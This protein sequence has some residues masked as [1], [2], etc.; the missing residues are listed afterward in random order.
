MKKRLLIM[1]FGIFV[2]VAQALAQQTTVTG[3]VFDEDRLPL[4]GASVRVKG[5]ATAV[6]TSSDGYYSIKASVG[7]TLVFSFVG[8]ITQEITIKTQVIDVVLKSDAN[9]LSEVKITGAMGIKEEKRALGASSQS[10]KGSEVAQT[11]REN[12]INGLQ[13]RVAG[14]TI[15]STSGAPGAS[16]SIILRG[17]SSIN[18]SNQ[19]LIVIDGIPSDNNTFATGELASSGVTATSFENRGVDFTNRSSDFSPEDIEDITVLKGPEA[20]AL[21]GIDAANGAIIITTKRGKAGEGRINYS[22]AFKINH[23]T[24][25]PEVQRVYGPGSSGLDDETYAY[26]GSKY[27]EGT[28][29]Y[30]NISNFFQTSLTQKH[31]LSFEGGAD[32]ATYRIS[33][34]YNNQKDVVP[35]AGYDRFTLNGASTAK[36]NN[37]F[38]VDLSLTYSYSKNDKVFKGAGGPLIGLLMWPATDDASNYLTPGGL[39]RKIFTGISYANEIDNPYFSINKN[40]LY[41]INNRVFAATSLVITPIKDLSFT[42]RVGFDVG[43][44]ESMTFQ[45]P[46]SAAAYTRKGA[47]NQVTRTSQNLNI[48]SFVRYS[49]KIIPKL[50][51]NVLGGAEIKTEESNALSTYGEKFLEPNFESINNTDGLSRKVLTTKYQRRVASIYGQVQFNYDKILYVTAT[52]RNDWTSTLPVQNNS[53]FYPSLSTSL[54]FTDIKALSGIKKV[55]NYGK[56]KASIAQVGRDARAYKIYPALQF[57]DNSVGGYRYGFTGPNFGLKPEMATSYEFGTELSFLNSRINVEFA[58]YKKKTEDQIVRDIRASY[59]TGFVLTDMNGGV[60]QNHGYETLL[61]VKPIM[62]RDFT[63]NVIANFDISRSK[64][65]SLPRD[66]PESYNSDTWLYKDI[67]KSARPGSSLTA[68]SGKFYLRNDA[69]DILIDPA[70]GLPYRNQDFVLNGTDTWPKWT[71][72]LTNEFSFKDFRLSFLLDF[73]KG[74]DVLNATEHYLTQKGLAMRT[75]DRETPRVIKG[76][77]RDGKENTANPTVNNIVVNPFFDSRYYSNISEELFIE[78]NI[79][80]IRLR[81]VTLSYAIP[82]K[83]LARQKFFKSASAFI[84]ATDV[85]LITNY[86]GADPIANGNNA[87]TVGAGGMGI[88]Y[89]NFP[90]STGINIGVRIGL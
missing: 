72:G 5:Q 86:S 81:D 46:E 24:K 23:V 70:S 67:R 51:F 28:Q 32:K 88:D 27:R 8:T 71:L 9:Q 40:N 52:G 79:N 45:H 19:P 22:N 15:N 59:A 48:N 33:S 66:L 76:V 38:N 87:A 65:V 58:Y 53:F 85:F 4:P 74:G 3:K 50:S 39:R 16:S 57:E 21:Y 78:R 44:F 14:L 2:L 89:G 73:R 30:D 62:K 11:Q 35:N 41:D 1:L 54:N 75:L 61:T 84:T 34:T 13:G 83:V 68:F 64:V 37:W 42:T 26:F 69:G 77:L 20:A 36:V 7:Q 6:S 17:I 63:W 12:F 25:E 47:L 82:S 56:L 60:T 18:S 49:K 80:W 29:F 31:N 55:L 43:T 10:I 90:I